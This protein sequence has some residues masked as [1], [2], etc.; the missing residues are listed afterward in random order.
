[1][2]PEIEDRL[3]YLHHCYLPPEDIRMPYEV[4]FLSRSRARWRRRFESA[5]PRFVDRYSRHWKIP[6]IAS[7]R[8]PVAS[9]V[10]RYS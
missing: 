10:E 4:D 6:Q 9:T 8:F 2:T 5:E 3:Q 7:S 1:M